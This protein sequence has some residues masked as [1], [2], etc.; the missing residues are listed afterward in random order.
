MRATTVS[1]SSASARSGSGWPSSSEGR[2][3][4]KG[5]VSI[6]RPF[7]YR[8]PVPVSSFQFPVSSFQFPVSSFQ[9]PVSSSEVPSSRFQVDLELDTGY[10]L[11]CLLFHCCA[12]SRDDADGGGRD[13]RTEADED[14]IGP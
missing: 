1:P 9:F 8:L 5:R 14:G 12:S 6:T 7:F 13:C 10:W 4:K 2:I 11:L 3:E